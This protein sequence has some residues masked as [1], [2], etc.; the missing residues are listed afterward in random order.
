MTSTV[1]REES[2]QQ[3]VSP[4]WSWE[5]PPL[6]AMLQ[7]HEFVTMLKQ[8][9]PAE[10]QPH[11]AREGTHGF[12]QWQTEGKNRAIFFSFQ[13]EPFLMVT[14]LIGEG[15]PYTSWSS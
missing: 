11:L 7:I 8:E 15:C 2:F 12:Q 10:Q 9:N 3:T 6:L 4:G 5:A 14:K 13:K 1:F